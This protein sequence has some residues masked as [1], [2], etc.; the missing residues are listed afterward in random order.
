M[1]SRLRGRSLVARDVG[2][3]AKKD[4][5]PVPIIRTGDV[6]TGEPASFSTVMAKALASVPA[7]NG[8]FTT[9]AFP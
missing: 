7:G 5:S 4:Y 8:G 6:A 3:N 1:S 2:K 9:V